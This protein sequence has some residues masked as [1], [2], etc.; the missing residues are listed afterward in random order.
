MLRDFEKSPERNA[1]A[2]MERRTDLRRQVLPCL[3]VPPQLLLTRSSSS[4]RP[5]RRSGRSCIR[6]DAFG[7]GT[8][9]VCLENFTDLF[10][11]PLYLDPSAAPSSSR[12]GHR[13]LDGAALLLA[14]LADRADRAAAALS[15]L[16]IWPYA[17]AP[18]VAAVLWIFIFHPQVGLLG[19]G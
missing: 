11:D 8:T 18:A 19:R 15:T 16:L 9:F 12:R 5:G 3:L 14:V 2:G 17:V 4:G 6:Q 7:L 1:S 10:A 13:A